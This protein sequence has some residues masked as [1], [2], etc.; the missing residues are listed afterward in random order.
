MCEGRNECQYEEC[1]GSLKG[2]VDGLRW[3]CLPECMACLRH[4]DR[5]SLVADAGE[6]L[7]VLEGVRHLPV[8]ALA[9]LFFFWGVCVCG[10]CARMCV[11]LDTAAVVRE[12]GTLLV[13]ANACTCTHARTILE[14]LMMFLLLPGARP[15]GRM[16]ESTSATDIRASRCG[17]GA[18][19]NSPFVTSFT[20]PS[21]VCAERI[22]EMRSSNVFWWSRGIGG[23]GYRWSITSLIKHARRR[24]SI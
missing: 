2:G 5:C 22:T 23:L 4:H 14:V 11:D 9:D 7:E 8:E 21:V 18:K 17:V 12:T 10:R 16:M 15:T 24:A 19:R 20:R 13:R 1:A 6:G 3:P